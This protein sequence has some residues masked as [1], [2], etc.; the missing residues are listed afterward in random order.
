M[1]LFD[2]FKKTAVSDG[3]VKAQGDGSPQARL[4]E[5]EAMDNIIQMMTRLPD[6]DE[7]LKKAGVSRH[8]LSV[9]LFDDEIGQAC[10]TRL[11]ALLTVPAHVFPAEGVPEKSVE[12]TALL[13]PHLF[14]LYP[15]MRAC[16]APDIS[17]DR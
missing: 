15:K 1:G 4:F 2:F 10:E 7:V 3:V 16:H 6:P 12:V 8:R 9:L 14:T 5:E 11:D 17:V 13:E